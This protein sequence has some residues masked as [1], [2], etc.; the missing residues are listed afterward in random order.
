M[1]DANP[2]VSR[3]GLKLA[4][5]LDAFDV[6]P[7]DFICADLG[8]NVGGFTDCLLQRGATQVY[9]VDTGYGQLAWKLRQDDRV[10]VM[11]RTNAMH[12]DVPVAS[13]DLVVLDMGWTPQRHAIP[14]ALRW[15]P[16]HIVSLV[17]PHYEASDRTKGQG[18][19]E[20]DEAA[21]VCEQV[22]AQAEQWGVRLI[23]HIR[24]P[25]VGGAGK[26]KRGNIEFLAYFQ[27]ID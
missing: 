4:A 7:A 24:S 17:K 19:L 10:E 11:E 6:D 9:A 22:L 15:N 27:P 23:D 25:V 3:G 2:Y 12:V 13:V 8:C 21:Q 20:E 1:P 16:K 26:G 18:K 5:A 14:A